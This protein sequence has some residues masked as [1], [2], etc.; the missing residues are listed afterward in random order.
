MAFIACLQ[1]EAQNMWVGCFRSRNLVRS[2]PLLMN[3]YWNEDSLLTV[4]GFS[5]TVFD[6]FSYFFLVSA[7]TEQLPDLS[8]SFHQSVIKDH[9]GPCI[10]KP[11]QGHSS[12][13]MLV[14]LFVIPTHSFLRYI[15]ELYCDLCGQFR[16]HSLPALPFKCL[17]SYF[18][19]FSSKLYLKMN[20]GLS[21]GS[22]SQVLS[23]FD[24]FL[25]I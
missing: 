17:K 12:I 6:Q 2:L 3:Y 23:K 8:Q 25:L 20:L 15:F 10:H 16:V 4:H 14:I 1:I 13:V 5:V 9:I 18:L 22:V 24:I 19:Y 7:R 11:R 21:H